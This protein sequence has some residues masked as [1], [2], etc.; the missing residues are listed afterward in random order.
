[1]KHRIV[2]WMM[3]LVLLEERDG[4]VEGEPLGDADVKL[5]VAFHGFEGEEVVPV[6][7][8]LYGRDAVRDGVVEGDRQRLAAD[9]GARWRDV[10]FDQST[11]RSFADDAREFSVRIVIE[12]AAGWVGSF[13]RYTGDG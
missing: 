2:E 13:G 3:G 12:F 8:V 5:M 10:G 6:G 11:C 9:G 1:M 4:V 7:I